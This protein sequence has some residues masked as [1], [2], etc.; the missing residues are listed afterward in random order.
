MDLIAI[1]MEP[2]ATIRPSIKA[3]LLVSLMGWVTSCGQGL[4]EREDSGATRQ[5]S[6]NLQ[7]RSGKISVDRTFDQW[8]KQCQNLPSN[9]LLKGAM[10]ER[11][12][13][14]I[15]DPESLTRM[16]DLFIEQQLNGPLSKSEAWVRPLESKESFLN[17]ST[18]Y[19]EKGGTP[20]CR[21]P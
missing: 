3:L 2:Q 13:L 14:P 20:S 21:L 5:P 6:P 9:R 11:S 15:Q 16:L 12:L 7:D 10:P 19:F 1:T 8:L 17:P 18:A 4:V